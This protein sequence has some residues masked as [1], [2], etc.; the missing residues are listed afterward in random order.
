MQINIEHN[1][2]TKP[3][4]YNSN[5]AHCTCGRRIEC[6]D[7]TEHM[8]FCLGN[9]MKYIWRVDLKEAGID[10]LKK[11][12]WYLE[13]EVARREPVCQQLNIGQAIAQG[14]F[15]RP[16]PTTQTTGN[17]FTGPWQNFQE[18]VNANGQ[19]NKGADITSGS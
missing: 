11:A 17:V 16:I 13:R 8:N 18:Y 14:A 4:H 19:D 1:P 3:V 2:I 12:I 15:Q 10:D 7:I 5:E 6:I 9:A